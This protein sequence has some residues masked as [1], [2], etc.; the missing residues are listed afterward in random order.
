MRNSIDT[1]GVGQYNGKDLRG[2]WEGK[3]VKWKEGKNASKKDPNKEKLPP[4]GTYTPH[5]V[6]YELF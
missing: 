1:P 6:A 5:P 2:K 3:V 4:V